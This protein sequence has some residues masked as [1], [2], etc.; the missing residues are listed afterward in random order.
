[1]HALAK[2]FHETGA[3]TDNRRSGCPKVVRTDENNENFRNPFQNNPSTSQVQ[4]ILQLG[5]SP[6]R[7]QTIMKDLN[8]RTWRLRLFHALD[9]D[10]F[11]RLTE[12]CEWLQQ[13]MNDDIEVKDITWMDEATFKL[14]G[15]V[16]LHNAVNYS[17]ENPH[18][19]TEINISPGILYS[20]GVLGP[21]FF[22]G[23]SI[24]RHA[25]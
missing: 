9:D 6:R 5:I 11:D 14:N 16:N 7:L 21:H 15:H 23:T 13:E 3:A 18:L 4:A 10:D 2:N 1:M 12:F 8:L 20:N 19:V 17:V 25:R 24:P 22:D